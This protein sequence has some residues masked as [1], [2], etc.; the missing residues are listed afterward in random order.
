MA[1]QPGLAQQRPN[2]LVESDDHKLSQPKGAQPGDP[3]EQEGLVTAVYHR[4]NQAAVPHV[5]VHNGREV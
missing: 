4:G 5:R 2:R 3:I 1:P